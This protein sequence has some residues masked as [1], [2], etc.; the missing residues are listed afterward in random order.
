MYTIRSKADTKQ[1]AHRMAVEMINLGCG[2]SDIA[3]AIGRVFDLTPL[4]RAELG[5][6][7]NAALWSLAID[8]K[9]E[10]GELCP[11][12]GGE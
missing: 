7:M 11:I 6:T 2:K 10:I 9:K 5:D 3:K 12:A 4:E 8:G 1:A